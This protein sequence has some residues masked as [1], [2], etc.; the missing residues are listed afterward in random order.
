MTLFHD[1]EYLLGDLEVYVGM[2]S[3]SANLTHG[4]NMMLGS[5]ASHGGVTSFHGNFGNLDC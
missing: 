1:L 2:P 5:Q 4:G 3:I